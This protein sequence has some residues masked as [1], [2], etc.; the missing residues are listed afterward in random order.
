MLYYFGEEEDAVAL[1]E[2][3]FAPAGYN[4]QLV[5]GAY[6]IDCSDRLLRAYGHKQQESPSASV[7]V[8]Q[9][10]CPHQV[11]VPCKKKAYTAKNPWIP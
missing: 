11:S 10:T 6:L 9:M 8:C 3:N 2:E 4:I 1:F 5:E 7:S